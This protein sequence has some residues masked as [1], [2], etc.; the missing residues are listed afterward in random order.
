MKLHP[1]ATIRTRATVMETALPITNRHQPF[2]VRIP[3]IYPVRLPAIAVALVHALRTVLLKPTE[4]FVAI[5]PKHAIPLSIAT[6][7]FW[8]ALLNY[9]HWFA[10]MDCRALLTNVLMAF[11]AITVN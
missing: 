10:M 7:L 5:L 6:V 4:H 1:N 8:I 3:P 9:L 2:A 11:V